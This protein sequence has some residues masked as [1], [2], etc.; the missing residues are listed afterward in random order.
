MFIL[1]SVI[2]INVILFNNVIRIVNL[3]CVI[4]YSRKRYTQYIVIKSRA[5]INQ[6]EMY[7]MKTVNNRHGSSTWDHEVISTMI[8]IVKR[9]KSD[10][11]YKVNNAHKWYLFNHFVNKGEDTPATLLVTLPLMDLSIHRTPFL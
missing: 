3:T 2:V 5:V 8:F 4:T 7:V 1:R 11:T 10:W 9:K 6:I